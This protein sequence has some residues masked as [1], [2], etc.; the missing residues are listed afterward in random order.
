MVSRL[1][2]FPKDNKENEQTKTHLVSFIA[3]N[4]AYIGIRTSSTLFCPN[5]YIDTDIWTKTVAFLSKSASKHPHLDKNIWPT[6]KKPLPL[7]R[8]YAEI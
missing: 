2:L 7:L 6:E 5:L 3:A 4:D 1:F 8:N